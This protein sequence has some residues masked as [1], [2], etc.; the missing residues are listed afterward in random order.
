M[1][2]M[3]FLCVGGIALLAAS[4]FSV[5]G[6]C[7][8]ET[9]A[10]AERVCGAISNTGKSDL[11]SGSGQLTAEARGLVA[12]ALGTAQGDAKFEAT[13]SSYENVV[14]EE[15]AKEHAN[16]RECKVKMVNV[17]VGQACQSPQK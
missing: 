5:L 14:R 8:D 6:S 4:P 2:V 9:A 7:L 16:V 1:K 17:A 11:V 13:V 15:L 3:N 10:F 12:K